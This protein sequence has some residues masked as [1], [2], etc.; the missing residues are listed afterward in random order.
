MG[1]GVFTMILM[2]GSISLGLCGFALPHGW[3]WGERLF[4]ECPAPQVVPCS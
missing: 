2:W 4:L 1:F 3:T